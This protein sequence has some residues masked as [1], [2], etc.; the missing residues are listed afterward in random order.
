MCV[1]GR[2]RAFVRT[3]SRLLELGLVVANGGRLGEGH[4][5][6]GGRKH[7]TSN[8]DAQFFAVPNIVHANGTLGLRLFLLRSHYE[9]P[10]SRIALCVCG[11]EGEEKL[12]AS[13][14]KDKCP[15][16]I[17]CVAQR[18]KGTDVD[19]WVPFPR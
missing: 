12:P 16:N 19:T 6:G 8:P 1:C 15:S 14:Y 7:T 11:R 2:G 13:V 17:C 9:M 4:L 3:L 5:G 10:R 18:K